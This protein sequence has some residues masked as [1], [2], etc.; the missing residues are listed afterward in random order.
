[1]AVFEAD[2][3]TAIETRMNQVGLTT[4][5]EWAA[6]QTGV[7]YVKV[8]EP[9]PGGASAHGAG[10]SLVRPS[11]GT[12]RVTPQIA[13]AIPGDYDG[14]F[15]VDG[16]DLL[17]WQRSLGVGGPA[18]T[19]ALDAHG[20]ETYLPAAL[21]G[22]HGWIQL[23][24]PTGSAVV[25]STVVFQGQQ[26]VRVDR[27]PGA[28]N[29]WGVPLGGGWPTGRNV[30]VQWD[31]RV[32]ATGATNGALGPFLGVEAYD[33]Q[34]VFGLLGSL[35]VDATTLEVLYQ[36]QDDGI[37]VQAGERVVP[38]VW[39][40]Y[41]LF[42]DFEVH[43][44]TVYLDGHPLATT[45]F[46]DRGPT[47]A[48]LDQLTDADIS[49]LAAQ[50]NSVSRNR[51]GTA[52]F[53]NFRIL[54]GIPSGALPADGNHDGIVDGLDLAIWRFHYGL[55]LGPGAGG[56]ASAGSSSLAPQAAWEEPSQSTALGDANSAEAART[57]PSIADLVVLAQRASANGATY[58]EPRPND[59][60]TV[61]EKLR[62]APFPADLDRALE[63]R[64]AT[65]RNALERGAPLGQ[66][67]AEAQDVDADPNFG[68]RRDDAEWD[69]A[70]TRLFD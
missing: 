41:A 24:P 1:V 22:Q 7:N 64:T 68:G 66:A 67:D 9:A 10:V 36:R 55:S 2:G 47:H 30:L 13:S 21:N 69:A 51:A 43:Q 17:V 39:Y 5:L 18:S 33:D 60:S 52:Y 11:G 42:F 54:D 37:L 20:F 29:R 63:L 57:T 19:A 27:A 45:G 4:I 58:S 23:G 62:S 25:Q 50:A 49:A 34:G 26:A 44:Y 35:G 53:D 46:V 3:A 28:D 16:G 70:L 15:D 48:A 56:A 61:R 8:A 65:T 38:D 6:T 32:A 14:D 40:S 31:M 12:Y 59:R